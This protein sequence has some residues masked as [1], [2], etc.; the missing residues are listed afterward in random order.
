MK[1]VYLKQAAAFIAALSFATAALAQYV[2]VDDKG[3][4]QFSDMPPPASVPKTRILRQPSGMQAASAV[5]KN[6][7]S[8]D[9]PA[10]SV[11]SAAPVTSAEKN[12]DFMKRRNEQAE[13][14]KKAAEEAK[15][16]TDNAQNCERARGYAQSL[17]SGQ[18]AT[19][20]DKN[21][22]RAFLSDEE[23]AG[24]LQNT[25]RILADCK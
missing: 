1:T 14:D 21:G 15:R 7:A 8:A 4:K 22:E 6:A 20:T 9:A 23:R 17:E 2:W 12:T 16:K 10:E 18:R 25:K 3:V 24:D 19:R 11:K 5:D 13:K